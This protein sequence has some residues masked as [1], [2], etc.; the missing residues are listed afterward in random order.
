MFFEQLNEGYC[1]TYLVASEKARE[2]ALID[3]VLERVDDYLGYLDG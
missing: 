2:A 3:P 1:R